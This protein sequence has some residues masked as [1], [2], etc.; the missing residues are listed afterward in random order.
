MMK[1]RALVLAGLM[2]VLSCSLAVGQSLSLDHVDGLNATGGLEMG[3]PVTFY[4][5]VTGDNDAHSGITNGFQVYSPTG[6]QWGSFVGDTTGTL[7]KAQFDGGFF[8]SHFSADGIGADTVGF[9]AF[10]FFAD[11]LPAGFDDTAY[12]IEIGPID[13]AYNGGQICLDSAY[14]PPSGVWKWAGPEVLPGWDG[15]HCYTIGEQVTNPQITCPGDTSVFLCEPDTLCF[16]FDTTDAEWVTA[17]EPAYIDGGQV[18]VPL[19]A[20]GDLEI[21]LIAGAVEAADTC[22]FTITAAINSPPTVTLSPDSMTYVICDLN[23]TI[24]MAFGVSDPDENIVDTA[25]NIGYI[26]VSDIGPD[27]CFVPDTAGLFEVVVTATD[28]CGATHSATR[29]VTVVEG[30]SAAI[31]CPDPVVD[32]LCGSGVYCVP[33]AITPDTATVTVSPSGTYVWGTGLFCVNLTESGLHEF[34][35]IAETQCGADTCDIQL[36]ITVIELPSIDCP[37]QTPYVFLADPGEAC[38]GLDIA[39]ADQIEVSYGSWN[40]GQLCFQADT[41]GLYSFVVVATNDCA[42]DT[43]E[44]SVN[45]QVGQL[46]V[47]TIVRPDPMRM[48]DAYRVDPMYATIYLGNFDDGH[49]VADIDPTTIVINNSLIP[50]STAIISDYPG[51]VGEVMEITEPIYDFIEY[52]MPLYDTTVATYTVSGLFTDDT[53]FSEVGQVRLIGILVGDVNVDGQVDIADM[54]YLI[55]YY[56][57]GGPPPMLLETADM[58]KNQLLDISDLM[59]LIDYMFGL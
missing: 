39:H 26:Y 8:I 38:I 13:A 51:F 14:Y 34:R 1:T 27:I 7:G 58:D 12:T 48:V 4:I 59:L 43:C 40:A 52:Y 54:I 11:G 25:T 2:T 31:E 30:E 21:E 22:S 36:D 44:L 35:L 45:V 49:T 42:A 3:V 37:D 55:D 24:C 10:R 5:R 23:G 15:P 29:W 20:D 47:T 28:A 18:C 17:G 56:F 57:Q 41:T 33:V 19:L 32:T 6:A 53:E 16:P 9:G 46:D 50:T